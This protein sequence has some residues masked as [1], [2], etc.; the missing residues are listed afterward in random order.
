M[1]DD[2][3]QSFLQMIRRSERGRLKI[4]LGFGPGVGKTYRMLLEAHRLKGEG[5]DVVVGFVETHGR[6]ETAKLL[7][8]LEIIPRRKSEYHDIVVEEM[9]IDAVIKRH[10]QVA[11]VDELA[12]TNVPGSRSAKRYQ[13]VQDILAAGIHV[14][15][16][17]NIQHLESLYNTVEQ[18]IGVKVRERIPDSVLAEAD[19]IVNIDL[20]AEDLQERLREG[21]IY[22][23]ERV[24]TSLEN[25]F[26]TSNLEHL[27]ELALRELAS[28]L[29]FK[30]REI[31]HDKIDASM[32][33]V[34]DQIMVCLSSRGP[35]SARLLR[36]ASRLAGRLNRN[37]YAVYVQTPSEEP[38]VIDA[39]TQRLLADTLTL[40]NQLG[41]MV[42]T[43]KG[44]NVAD[45]ILRFAREYRV[46]QVVIGRPRPVPWRKRIFNHR[47]V[48]ED[49]IHR[50]EGVT[51]IV[52]DAESEERSACEFTEPA[53]AASMSAVR[54][55]GALSRLLTPQRI[56]IW[57][58]PAAR[59]D[60]RK[61]L[62][63]S[64]LVTESGLNIESVMKKLDEREQQGSTFLN[65]GIA[66]PH[67]RLD[68]L[69]TPQVALGLTRAGLLDVATER[70]IEAVFLLLSPTTGASVHLQLL[71]KAGRALQNRE[72]RSALDRAASPVE[73]LDAIQDFE[74]A[75]SGQPVTPPR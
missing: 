29:D 14:I 46:G 12:H 43:F 11:I 6:E 41:A 56:V 42:F 32:A 64:I 68:G 74:A 47:S 72:L 18:L 34:P 26:T 65:E 53:G 50:S 45:T 7:D 2:R 55:A 17:L 5:I 31:S 54:P 66:L 48:A 30:R 61:R 38:T 71:A 10:P 39:V 35:N 44:Q 15:S 52:V 3:A 51:L 19:Q 36:F 70:P 69:Q 21:K 57:D 8:G 23:A 40:A 13:D 62:V 28:Q 24:Q 1:P 67:A 58:D 59:Q 16:A 22:P 37:W 9:D 63:N 75:S 25:F 27:R 60:V 49:L 73:A 20:S 4:Y 33:S